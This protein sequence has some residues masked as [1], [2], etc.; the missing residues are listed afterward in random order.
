MFWQKMYFRLFSIIW[1]QNGPVGFEKKN[2]A[3]NKNNIL[4]EI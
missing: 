4:A 3:Y 2:T 1:V